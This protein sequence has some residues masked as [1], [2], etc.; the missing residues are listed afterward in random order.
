MTEGRLSYNTEQ[1]RYGLLV[2]DLW[3]HEGLHC[4]E[5]LDVMVDGAW[6]PTRIEMDTT[7]L[8][9]LVGTP[10]RGEGLEYVRARL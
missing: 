6:T 8:W 4:G 2:G 5:Q 10:Y 1:D 9:Y 3:H 7:G